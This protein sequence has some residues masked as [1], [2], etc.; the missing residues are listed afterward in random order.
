MLK[1]AS[2]DS[3]P[4]VISHEKAASE[5]KPKQ[6][7]VAVLYSYKKHGVQCVFAGVKYWDK[8]LCDLLLLHL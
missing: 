8:S 4:K 5:Q 6:L 1:G 7:N 2:V 3:L